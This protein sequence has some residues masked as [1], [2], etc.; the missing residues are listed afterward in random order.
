VLPDGGDVDT[1][2]IVHAADIWYS[3]K[4]HWVREAQRLVAARQGPV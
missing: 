1:K 2:N 4:R 3:V